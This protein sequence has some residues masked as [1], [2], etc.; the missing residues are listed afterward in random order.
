MGEDSQ[1]ACARCK[2]RRASHDG[3]LLP[4]C[5]AGK[6]PSRLEIEAQDGTGDFW[7]QRVTGI[8]VPI[9]FMVVC[10]V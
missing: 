5:G 3:A 6:R 4:G 2:V 1:K 7:Q 10:W 8:S 9:S